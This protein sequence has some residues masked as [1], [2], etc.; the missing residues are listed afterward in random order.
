[1][2]TGMLISIIMI[3]MGMAFIVLAIVI[4]LGKVEQ[5]HSKFEKLYTEYEMNQIR[6]DAFMAGVDSFIE[7][8]K[9]LKIVA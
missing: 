9:K 6:Q 3:M 1:M 2:I 5:G 4:M 7:Q 8:K